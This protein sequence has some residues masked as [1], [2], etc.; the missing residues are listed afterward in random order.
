MNINQIL[1][2]SH[3]EA[4]LLRRNWLFIFLV[5][6]LVGGSLAAQWFIQV[7]FPIHFLNALSCSIPFVS[8]FLF[9]F[10]QGIFILFIAGDFIRRDRSLDSFE[11]L[12][13][14]SHGN[15][16]YAMGKLLAVV[17]SFVVLNV[18]VIVITW[19]FHAIISCF[20]PVC[21]L[22][23]DINSP[24]FIVFGRDNFVDNRHDKNMARGVIVLDRIYLF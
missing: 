13:T 23:H 20:F 11:S 16:D 1:L 5:F 6:L 8:A 4:K 18:L 7:D 12:S 24:F 9:N 10:I 17:G 14:R 2:I 21:I 15:G 3:Y 19:G 22:F